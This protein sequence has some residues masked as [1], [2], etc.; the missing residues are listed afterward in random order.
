MF[1]FIAD[2]DNSSLMN[3]VTRID[4]EII[5]CPPTDRNIE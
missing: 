1:P 5:A 3:D 2:A 4:S